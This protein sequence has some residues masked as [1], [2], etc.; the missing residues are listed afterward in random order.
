M[1]PPQ[2]PTN[3][4]GYPQQQQAYN[5]AAAIY[6][7]HSASSPFLQTGTLHSPAVSSALDVVGHSSNSP[8]PVQANYQTGHFHPNNAMLP[9]G[10]IPVDLAQYNSQLYATPAI[11]SSAQPFNQQQLNVPAHSRQSTHASTTNNCAGNHQYGK[12]VTAQQQQRQTSTQPQPPSPSAAH[13]D[14]LTHLSE[15][16]QHADRSKEHYKNMCN[17]YDV[18]LTRAEQEMRRMLDHI[19]MHSTT[20]FSLDYPLAGGYQPPAN[21]Q[22]QHAQH[23]H[24]MRL[25]STTQRQTSTTQP[26]TGVP[27]KASQQ[28][29]VSK[30]PEV[31]QQQQQQQRVVANEKPQSV[32]RKL[33]ISAAESD[34]MRS[35]GEHGNASKRPAFSATQPATYFLDTN[36]AQQA[37][38]L[39]HSFQHAEPY[40]SNSDG[41]RPSFGAAAAYETAGLPN[42]SNLRRAAQTNLIQTF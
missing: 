40:S 21:A 24:H 6:A 32:K 18:M 16:L 34:Y 20:P 30:A 31:T 15:L 17:K 7:R 9:V 1:L 5:A 14:Q 33:D 8:S 19:A 39:L 26:P 36:I 23:H 42:S 2:H 22:P 28:Q 38:N 41:S 3:A 13:G 25:R 4:A 29:P 11:V 27:A 35:S 37:S 10:S 12:P